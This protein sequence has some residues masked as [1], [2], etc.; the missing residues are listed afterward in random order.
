MTI[1]YFQ[2]TTSI[3][4]EGH[5]YLQKLAKQRKS[6]IASALRNVI[7]EHKK[8]VAAGIA[9]VIMKNNNKNY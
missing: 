4:W 1:N 8:Y 9:V 5:A 2:M 6:S 7:A 3:D